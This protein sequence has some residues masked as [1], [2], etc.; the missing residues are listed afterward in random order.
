M[1]TPRARRIENWTKPHG[2][3][4][5]SARHEDRKKEEI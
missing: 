5:D 1:N 3:V 4:E 2:P